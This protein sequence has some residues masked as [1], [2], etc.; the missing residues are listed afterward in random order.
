LFLDKYKHYFFNEANEDEQ[1]EQ[2]E[3][4]SEEND[5]SVSNAEQNFDNAEKDM[6]A[7]TKDSNNFNMDSDEDNESEN[8]SDDSNTSTDDGSNEEEDPESEG[9]SDDERLKKYILLKQYNE[10]SEIM[11][12][13]EKSVSLLIEKNEKINNNSLEY[14]LN[15]ITDLR[16]KMN[17][18]I[19]ERFINNYYAVLLKEFFFFKASLMDLVKF[20]EKFT[21]LDNQYKQ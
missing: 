6:N 4:S 20:V 1:K 12:Y 9:M 21:E 19:R 15:K 14:V 7:A 17:L 3:T 13:L 11:N 2:K 8:D 18:V 16:E 5:S 10:L